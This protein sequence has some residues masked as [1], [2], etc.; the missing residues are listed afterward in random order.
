M[1]TA[2][3]VR[4]RCIVTG[5]SRGLGA[6][7]ARRLWADGADLLLVARSGDQLARL[8]DDL[9]ERPG[10]CVHALAVDLAE[11][12]AREAIASAAVRVLGGVSVLI[13]NAALQGPIGSTWE[14]D[15]TGWEQT[16]E[17]N[18][19][20]PVDL[21]RRV[22]PLM[23]EGGWGKIVSISGGGATGARPRFAAYA[24]A[25][26]ALVRFSETLAEE[27]RTM[28]IDVNCVAPGAMP[29]AM[30]ESILAAGPERA[31]AR[32]YDDAVKISRQG[33]EVLDRAAALCAFLSSRESDGITGRL[34]S[35]VWDPW[36]TLASHREDL[37]RTDVYTL[38]RIVPADRNLPWGVE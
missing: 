33:P 8:I 19:L 4:R 18:L 14:T 37:Q 9:G 15:R 27:T 16:L 11:P 28:G 17:V 34:I 23:A 20:S 31:G 22:V 26:A 36:E 2:G 7:I 3:S 32:E 25:K 1:T 13:N 29:S 21:C 38:R 24:A 30:T 6:A 10:Q 35:A 5:A 12:A